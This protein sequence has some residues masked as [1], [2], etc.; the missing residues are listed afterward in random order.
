MEA[1]INLGDRLFLTGEEKRMIYM[2]LGSK[3][4]ANLPAEQIEYRGR[5][6]ELAKRGWGGGGREREGGKAKRER[7]D[8]K[9]EG[10]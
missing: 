1:A 8:K 2:T 4:T 5:R 6:K 7:G 3:I 9:R 10:V